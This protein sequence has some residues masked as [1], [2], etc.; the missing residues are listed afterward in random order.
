M[1]ADFTPIAL[2]QLPP[3]V[4]KALAAIYPKAMLR[5]AAKEERNDY[6]HYHIVLDQP[7]GKRETVEILENGDF[8]KPPP[9]RKDAK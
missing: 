4:K 1:A 2:E 7:D 3:L 9:K 8:V 5:S 6:V